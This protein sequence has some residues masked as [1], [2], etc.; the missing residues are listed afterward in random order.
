[1]MLMSMRDRNRTGKHHTPFCGSC[2]DSTLHSG[3]AIKATRRTARRRER[4][5]WK[6]EVSNN[7]NQDAQA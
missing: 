6:K 7:G 4:N 3:K 1:M 5:N 2:C